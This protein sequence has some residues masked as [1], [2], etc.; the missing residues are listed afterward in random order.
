[1][2]K[3]LYLKMNKN[4]IVQISFILDEFTKSLIGWKFKKTKLTMEEKRNLYNLIIKNKKIIKNALKL[5]KHLKV[6]GKKLIEWR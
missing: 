4:K 6:E 5:G 1:M 2:N 3:R